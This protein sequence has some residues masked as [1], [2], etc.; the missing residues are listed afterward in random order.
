VRHEQAHKTNLKDG[1]NSSNPNLNYMP[2]VITFG[3][4]ILSVEMR[5]LNLQALAQHQDNSPATCTVL[6]S[7]ADLAAPLSSPSYGK[8]EFNG[9]QNCRDG[10]HPDAMIKYFK[11]LL[12][13]TQD[14]T[15]RMTIYNGTHQFLQHMSRNKMYL[16][17][18]QLHA[19]EPC[20]YDGIV[21]QVERL[22]GEHISQNCQYTGNQSWCGGD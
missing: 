12:D 17:H 6:P 4:R 15:H 8:P 19:M 7:S 3:R 13:N 20:I 16:L 9:P 2:Q 22:D 1:W 5:E 21:V 10:K 11:A 14:A 18:E